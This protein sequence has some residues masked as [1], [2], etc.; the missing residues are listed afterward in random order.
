MGMVMQYDSVDFFLTPL[1]LCYGCSIIIVLTLLK[2]FN[3]V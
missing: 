3:I 2:E 1:Y